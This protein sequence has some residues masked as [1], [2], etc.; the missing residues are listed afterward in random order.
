MISGRKIKIAPREKSLAVDWHDCSWSPAITVQ[1]PVAVAGR[2]IKPLLPSLPVLH[3]DCHNPTFL[4]TM[5][6]TSLSPRR[7]RAG[8][9]LIELLVVIAIIAILAAMLMPALAAAK[10]AA[11]KAKAK[12]EMADIVNAINA[13]DSDYGRFPMISTERNFAGTNDFTTGLVFGLGAPTGTFSYDN[14]SNV[15]AVLMDLEKFPGGIVTSNLYHVYNPKSV[16]YLN[17]KISGYDPVN[18]PDPNPPGGVDNTGVYRDPWGNPYVISMNSSYNEQGCSDLLYS[19][20]S[21]SQNGPLGTAAG[22]NGLSNPNSPPDNNNF[23]FHGKVMVWSAG[24][25]KQ[26]DATAKANAGFN[27]DNI[28]SW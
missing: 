13:Y 17:P 1:S 12:V 18:N 23:L 11:L 8:F 16:K 3:T 2:L 22:F 20:Q 21:V 14:N 24:P 5:K 28:F 27:K 7:L 15:V 10:R 26:Y 6:T 4:K 25:D 19:R 9:T